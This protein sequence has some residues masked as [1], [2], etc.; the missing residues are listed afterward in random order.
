MQYLIGSEIRLELKVTKASTGAPITPDA[1]TLTLQPP[2]GD[3]RVY[4]YPGDITLDAAGNLSYLLLGDVAGA[5]L[6]RWEG[7]GAANGAAEGSFS[8]L[9][10]ALNP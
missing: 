9:A 1:A 3:A 5:W 10:S 8:V 6:Y 4:V 2:A 7:T